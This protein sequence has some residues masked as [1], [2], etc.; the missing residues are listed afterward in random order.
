MKFC[1]IFY[2]FKPMWGKKW[3]KSCPQELFSDFEFRENACIISVHI[4]HIFL[5]TSDE[6]RYQNL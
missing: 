5:Y 4:L 6:I 1:H 3:Y 2:I